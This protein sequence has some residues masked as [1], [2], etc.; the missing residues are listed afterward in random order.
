MR[1]TYLKMGLIE[2]LKGNHPMLYMS[3]RGE[4]HVTLFLQDN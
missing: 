4:A 3:K 1:E 2:K